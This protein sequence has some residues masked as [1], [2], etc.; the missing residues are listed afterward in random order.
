M[1][2]PV[3]NGPRQSAP[4]PGNTHKDQAARQAKAEHEAAKREPVEKIIEGKVVVR[5]K[6]WYR[7]AANSIVADDASSIGEFVMADVVVPAIKNLIAEVVGQGTNRVL[8]GPNSR[9]RRGVLGGGRESLRTRYDH[10]SDREPSRRLSSRDRAQHNFADIILTTRAEALEVLDALIDRV[11]RF[12]MASVSDM[13][14]FVGVTG[15]YADRRYGWTDL[16]DADVRQV[17]DGFAIELPRPELL[18]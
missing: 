18:R 3:G 6:P 5:K 8:F 16:R 2:E 13:Y 15:S 9:P 12:G 10:M 14:D 17:R 11:D 1:S 4:I 7:R